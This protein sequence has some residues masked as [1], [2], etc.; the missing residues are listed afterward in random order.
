MRAYKETVKKIDEIKEFLNQ[1]DSYMDGRR[2]EA[3][4]AE[5]P[6]DWKE[7]IFEAFEYYRKDL[8]KEVHLGHFMR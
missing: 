1:L 4:S 2:V 5:A 8:E 3:F 6:E 7:I